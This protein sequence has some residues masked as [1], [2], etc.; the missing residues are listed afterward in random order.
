M[1]V[2]DVLGRDVSAP[3]PATQRNSGWHSIE[4]GAAIRGSLC[5]IDHDSARFHISTKMVD[6]VLVESVDSTGMA[7]PVMVGQSNENLIAFLEGI[8]RKYR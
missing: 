5:L 3:R 1:F 8:I 4:K 6:V 2:I 7:C